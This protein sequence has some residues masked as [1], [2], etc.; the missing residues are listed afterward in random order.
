MAR[1]QS[2]DQHAIEQ[3]GIPRLLLMEH[4]GRAL[5]QTAAALLSKGSAAS[6]PSIVVCCGTG[7]NGGDGFSASRHLELMGFPVRVILSGRLNQ[8]R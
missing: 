6:A 4:A 2:I 8:L 1:M 5:A 3:I 7:F